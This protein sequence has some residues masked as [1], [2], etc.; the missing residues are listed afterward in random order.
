[1]SQSKSEEGIEEE[2]NEGTDD[3][4]DMIKIEELNEALKY[5][6]KQEKLWIR[7]LTI[8]IVEIWRNRIKNTLTR[9]V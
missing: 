6:K 3:N 5:A 7:K 4:E 9:A 8:G 1:V 2:R